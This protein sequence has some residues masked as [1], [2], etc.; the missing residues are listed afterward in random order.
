MATKYFSLL[1]AI[2]SK[3]GNLSTLD[4][5][6]III[7]IIYKYFT[8]LFYF[9]FFG[10]D[11]RIYQICDLYLIIYFRHKKSPFKKVKGQNIWSHTM[12]C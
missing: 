10:C 9:I 1:L 6:L 3:Y 4:E 7:V 5:K 12:S 11:N 2:S 8:E